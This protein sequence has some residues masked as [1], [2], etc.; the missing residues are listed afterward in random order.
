MAGLFIEKNIAN[1][2]R[3]NFRDLKFCKNVLV[4]TV[5]RKKIIKTFLGKLRCHRN[6][7]FVLL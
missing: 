6:H 5:T 1:F 3:F 2:E 7:V 4:I